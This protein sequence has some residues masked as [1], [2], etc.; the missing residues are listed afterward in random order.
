MCES[1]EDHSVYMG[2]GEIKQLPLN[3]RK[4]TVGVQLLFGS[5][6]VELL[7]GREER[8]RLVKSEH[9]D[10][11]IGV[12]EM[13]WTD[14]EREPWIAFGDAGQPLIDKKPSHLR[15]PHFREFI[16]ELAQ[17]IFGH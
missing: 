2:V 12:A 14:V 17:Q 5:Q 1:L 10:L 3:L 16:L 7:P 13:A 4:R 15:R 11:K 8:G 9:F 6:T